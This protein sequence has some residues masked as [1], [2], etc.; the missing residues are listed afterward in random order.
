[1]TVYTL[2]ECRQVE[3]S[4][5]RYRRTA[6]YSRH[7]K[8]FVIR[9]LSFFEWQSRRRQSHFYW[10]KNSHIYMDWWRHWL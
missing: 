5:Q 2:S 8:S 3:S 10:V 6:N 9:S 7:P 4:G 1:V